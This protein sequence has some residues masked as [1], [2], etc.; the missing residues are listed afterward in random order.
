[1]L[2]GYQKANRL[3]DNALSLKQGF[4]YDLMPKGYQKANRLGDN[5]LSL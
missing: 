3:G 2:E 4:D 5:V 1:M